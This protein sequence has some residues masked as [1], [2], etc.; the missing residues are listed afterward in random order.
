MTKLSIFSPNIIT[1]DVLGASPQ[2][3]EDFTILSTLVVEDGCFAV[4]PNGRIDSA[5][6]L[7]DALKTS[8]AELRFGFAVAAGTQWHVAMA[9]LAEAISTE[10]RRVGE[11]WVRNSRHR[12][13]PYV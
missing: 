12:G 13:L 4:N 5:E 9:V 10:E 6:A 1:N 11:G 3:F 2:T 7:V 8:P